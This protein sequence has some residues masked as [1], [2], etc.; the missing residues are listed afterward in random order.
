MPFDVKL[1]NRILNVHLHGE[2]D[3]SVTALLKDDVEQL[4]SSDVKEVQV[5]A[6][7]VTYIDSSGVASLLFVRKLATRHGAPFNISALSDAASRVIHLAN[8]G[9][10][11]RTQNFDKKSAPSTEPT[12][13]AGHQPMADL[14]FSDADALNLFGD[15]TDPASRH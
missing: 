8:L 11:L 3:L 6:G 10:L 9:V 1:S 4:M 5:D 14:S 15:S 2:I 12:L 13:T 7:G